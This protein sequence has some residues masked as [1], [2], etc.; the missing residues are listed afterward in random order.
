MS[1]EDRAAPRIETTVGRILF[2][3][4]LPNE[5]PYYNTRIDK[6]MMGEI[7]LTALEKCGIEQTAE[8]LDRIKEVC[9]NY[10]TD[11][12]LSF[13]MDDIPALPEKAALIKE[14]ENRID[15]VQGQYENGLLTF[16][17]RKNKV[18]SIWTETRE[19]VSKLSK[20]SLAIE[21][22]VYS[23]IESGARG[24][25][26]QLNQIIGMKGLVTNP[27]GET[28]ELAVKGSFKE[29]LGVLEY[30]IST[31]GARKG[32]VDT[33]L[34]TSNAGYLTRRLVDVAQD[35]VVNESDC[36]DK[37]GM[38]ITKEECDAID[39]D[40]YDRLFGRSCSQDAVGADGET[41]VK[42]NEI[43][44][45]DVTKR[46]REAGMA[47]VRIRSLLSCR[48]VR[49]V[50]QKCYGLDLA[51]TTLVKAGTAVG[52]I[53]AQ[54][55]GEPGTQ[56]TMRTFHSGGVVGADITQGLPRVEE[57]FEVRTPKNKA[58]LSDVAGRV[59]L[60]QKTR[61]TT[62]VDGKEVTHTESGQK[63]IAVHFEEAHE[64]QYRFSPRKKA[65]LVS[66]DDEKPAK[67]VKAA[68][69]RTVHVQDGQ[70]VKEGDL[71]FTVG[72]TETNARYAG[73]VKLEKDGV[74]VLGQGEGVQEYIIPSSAYVIVKD[75]DLVTAG[76]SLTEGDLD[77]QLYFKYKGKLET[78]KYIINEIH[79]IYISQGQKL[80]DKHI[81]VIIR[82]IFS[83]M[84]VVD[85]GDTELLAGE[86]VEQS[87]LIEENRRVK[88]E[89][90]K[91]AK[92]DE[93][94]M[95]ITKAS[96]STRS[97]LS[98]ASFQETARILINAA[99][100]GKADYLE[101]LK[102][103]VIIGRLIPVG[104]GYEKRRKGE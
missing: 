14:A 58:I 88:K 21:G 86:I 80:N 28:I 2:N 76:D 71:L 91:E 78:Q 11:S 17:E 84:M 61:I 8:M 81:E 92:G 45:K 59:S 24:T 31:H 103:N 93:L 101:G 38:V 4:I 33:A 5:L 63:I 99:V 34:R 72:E 29:G 56:L 49:G 10:L 60:S 37:E 85:A 50:C 1:E 18:I 96:L 79:R 9:A 44:T 47:S 23:I 15:E 98:A 54:S 43:F 52:I 90:L 62:G 7:V 13:G 87:E 16:Q 30:F 69:I 40:F 3:K 25:W 97:W 53:A 65:V 95:G 6:K 67:P 100:S 46:A 22:S 94:L 77:L 70:H 19:K 64:E 83:R 57:L 68:K 66:H 20:V 74:K 55:L 41:V 102:E 35:V 51:Y 82:Q 32:L 27:L 75:G 42:R 89:G 39:V 12:G 104:T 26:A 36:Q 48:A 73:T